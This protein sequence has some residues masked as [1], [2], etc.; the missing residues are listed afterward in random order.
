MR[1]AVVHKKYFRE[2]CNTGFL[3]YNKQ[4]KSCLQWFLKEL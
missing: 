1:L 4:G 3:S 2:T